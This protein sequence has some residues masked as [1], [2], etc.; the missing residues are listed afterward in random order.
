MKE[1]YVLETH[2][3]GQDGSKLRGVF[4]T[5]RKAQA[6]VDK[7]CGSDHPDYPDEVSIHLVKMD[8]GIE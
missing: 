1:L 2:T 4:S 7:L 6:Y 5:P 3:D 8:E